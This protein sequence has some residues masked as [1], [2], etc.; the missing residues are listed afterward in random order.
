MDRNE[1]F[2]ARSTSTVSIHLAWASAN[3]MIDDVDAIQVIVSG[4]EEDVTAMR[5]LTSDGAMQV[6]QPTYGLSYNVIKPR[7]MQVIVRIPRAWKGV[8]DIAT[9]SGPL[10]VDG[11]C[12]TD[13]AFSTVSGALHVSHLSA[14]TTAIN[15]VTGSILAEEVDTNDLRMRTVSGDMDYTGNC[16]GDISINTVTGHASL[17]TGTPYHSF[18]GDSVSANMQLTAPLSEVNLHFRSMV[19]KLRTHGVSLVDDGVQV[20]FSSVSGNFN[21]T[22]Q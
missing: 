9:I 17:I 15:T 6:E 11:L 7:W 10:T 22:N 2:D 8:V 14:I 19:G 13:L 5:I 1:Q 12:G 20:N 18:D 21:L 4:D 3:I 16:T